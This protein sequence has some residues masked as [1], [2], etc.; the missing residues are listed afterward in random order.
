MWIC[1]CTAEQL[2]A[3]DR[4]F[5]ESSVWQAVQLFP[6]PPSQKTIAPLLNIDCLPL[7]L[8]LSNTQN[9]LSYLYNIFTQFFPTFPIC[10]CYYLFIQHVD[11]K[12]LDWHRMWYITSCSP[13]IMT[14]VNHWFMF[15]VVCCSNSWCVAVCCHYWHWHAPEGSVWDS[16]PRA[17]A[18][19]L[20]IKRD[21]WWVLIVFL[22]SGLP[23]IWGLLL[24]SVHQVS[25]V[26]SLS[27]LQDTQSL[28]ISHRFQHSRQQLSCPVCRCFCT[29]G[30]VSL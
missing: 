11:P 16:I 5:W 8:S 6:L 3:W 9:T 28:Q 21:G 25:T 29:W 12:T 30:R 2:C 26:S 24:T 22:L 14:L 17:V 15:S 10:P 7:P 19:F 20:Q 1:I 18:Q 27:C 13:G 4:F 23:L